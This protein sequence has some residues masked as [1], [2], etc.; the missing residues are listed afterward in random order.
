MNDFSEEHQVVTRPSAPTGT[1]VSESIVSRAVAEVQ[2]SMMIARRFPRDVVAARDRIL[3][4]CARPGLAAK[5]VY[6]YAR[7]GSDI[8][9]PSIRLAEAIM[10]GWGNMESG[11]VIL[12]S[13]KEKSEVMTYAVD[14]ET[15]ARDTKAFTVRHWRDT[16]QGGYAVKDERDIYELCANM[17]SRRKRA[18]MLSILPPDIVEEALEQ[19]STTLATS[20]E[21]TADTLTKLVEAFGEVGVTKEQIEAFIQRHLD[22]MSPAQL[23]RLRKIYN[24]IREG[25]AEP[26][27]FFAEVAGDAT[28]P[29]KTATEAVKAKVKKRAEKKAAPPAEPTPGA[30]EPIADEVAA[31]KAIELAKDEGEGAAILSR[32]DGQPFYKHVVDAFEARFYGTGQ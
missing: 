10:Q 25:I 27:D 5:A 1:A 31:L 17:A 3:Q 8:E 7:G 9:G 18:C 20:A 23:V 4:A 26:K 19:C 13:D 15:G 30:P 16:K 32:C 14:L 22:A 29:P 2:A 21:V 12:A 6:Q 28:E 24:S 11:V